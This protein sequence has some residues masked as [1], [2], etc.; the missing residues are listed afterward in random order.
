M[1]PPS[2]RVLI[3]DDHPVVRGGMKLLLDSQTGVDVVGEAPCG[4]TAVELA[5]K[6]KPDVVLMDLKM[7]EVNGIEGR[8][9]RVRIVSGD[10]GRAGEYELEGDRWVFREKRPLRPPLLRETVVRFEQPERPFAWVL[11]ENDGVFQ[12]HS[13]AA[14]ASCSVQAIR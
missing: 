13:D 9:V 7:P 10:Y 8:F 2:I 4:R 1:A 3:A 6:L 12:D 14:R 11:S 5:G